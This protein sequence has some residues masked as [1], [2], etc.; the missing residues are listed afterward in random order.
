MEGDRL[1]LSARAHCDSQPAAAKTSKT[2]E[3]WGS[4]FARA[5]CLR[6]HQGPC[7][8]VVIDWRSACAL[9]TAEGFEAVPTSWPCREPRPR[10]L[11]S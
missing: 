7:E 6:R 2:P 5:Q 9:R 3:G 4:E 10:G 1:G 8:C 11:V